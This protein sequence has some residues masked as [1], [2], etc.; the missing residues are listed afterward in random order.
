MIKIMADSIEKPKDRQL[1]NPVVVYYPVRV[2]LPINSSFS[3]DYK[4]VLK[5]KYAPEPS[6]CT[7]KM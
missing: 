7:N 4:P 5:P 1:L 6:S 3:L 2:S